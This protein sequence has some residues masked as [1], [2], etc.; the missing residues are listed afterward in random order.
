[1]SFKEDRIKDAIHDK[2]LWKNNALVHRGNQCSS[3]FFSL[4]L[5]LKI[6]SRFYIEIF[7]KDHCKYGQKKKRKSNL[8]RQKQVS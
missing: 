2:Q 8:F 5:F 6:H 7:T 1:M 4:L 3:F